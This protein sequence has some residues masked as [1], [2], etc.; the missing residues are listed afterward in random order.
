MIK[1]RDRSG[2]GIYFKSS[3]LPPYLKRAKNDEES[4]AWLYL[5]GI[6]IHHADF[7]EVLMARFLM[8]SKWSLCST[9]TINRLKEQWL[10]E[11]TGN[12]A[13]CMI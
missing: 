6:Y 1:V 13:A 2:N 12:V 5:V 9:S 11:H 7:N 4:L 3:L 8:K 10:E